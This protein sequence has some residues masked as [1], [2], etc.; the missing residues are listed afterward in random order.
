MSKS[1]LQDFLNIEI[2]QRPV[3]YEIIST[4]EDLAFDRH[5]IRYLGSEQD[6]ISAYLF[7]PKNKKIIG[8]VLVHH[9]HDSDRAIGKSEVAGITGDANLFF[10]PEL[11]RKGIIALAPDSIS[12]EDRRRSVREPELE[13]DT[14]DDI[15][16]HY[17]EMC[18]R[19]LNGSSLMKKV[20]E[21]SSI[22]I[23]VLM[24]LKETVPGHIGILGHSYG[25]NTVTFHSPFDDRIKFSCTSGSVCSYK[26]KIANRTGIEL[27]SVIPGFLKHYDIDDLLRLIS[28]RELLIL[29]ASEDKYSQDAS[30]VYTK[31][32]PTY[33]ADGKEEAILHKRYSGGHNLTK[34]RLEY[35][36]NWFWERFTGSRSPSQ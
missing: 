35:I 13:W 16:Q 17:N 4:R 14:D 20:I 32:K 29:S 11:A 10:C 3:T 27:S 28:P 8:S 33:Q 23:S 36:I 22:G 2:D 1:A 19:V 9:Q 30:E 25:G 26:T 18:Y 6:E 34:E 5:L 21:D 31:V 7:I 15:L 12:F 24:G